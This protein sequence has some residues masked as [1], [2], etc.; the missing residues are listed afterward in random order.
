MSIYMTE[1]EQLE[2]IKAWWQRHQRW[3]TTLLSAVLLMVAGYRYWAWHTDKVRHDAS[4]AY[5]QLMAAAAN[6]ESSAIEAYAKALVKNYPKTVYGDA[7][8]LMLAKHW[9]SE[10]KWEDAARELEYVALY[11]KMPALQQVARIRLARLWIAEKAFDK[12]LKY[13]DETNSTTYKP[14]IDELKADVYAATGRYDEAEALY[15]EAREEVKLRGVGNVFLE[16]KSNE[17][18]TL[19]GAAHSA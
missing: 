13:L 4:Q 8:R 5:E 7:A 3:I 12:A 19:T 9:V 14:L 2:A 18:A 16:M 1:A 11:A 15:R 17:L 6:Q 10:T